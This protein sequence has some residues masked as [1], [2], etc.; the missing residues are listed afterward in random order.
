MAHFPT[1]TQRL[2]APSV[3]DARDALRRWARSPSPLPRTVLL[4]GGWMVPSWWTIDLDRALRAC[5]SSGNIFRLGCPVL[6]DI[7]TLAARLAER[8]K[9]EPSLDVIGVSMGGMVAR[10]AARAHRS[11]RLQVERLYALASPHGGARSIAWL[12]PHHQARAL[13]RGSHFLRELNADPSS[14]SFHIETFSLRGDSLVSTAS[15]HAVPGVHHDWRNNTLLPA[16]SWVH[17][18]PRVIMTVV[19]KILGHLD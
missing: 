10:E 7:P 19:G 8:F 12:V 11:P 14:H 6:Y 1:L 9:L 5:V 2:E 16:H 4:L 18:D 3:R 17:R 13:V 15:A